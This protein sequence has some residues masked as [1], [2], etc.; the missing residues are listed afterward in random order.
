MSI[1]GSPHTHSSI[2]GDVSAP[3]GFLSLLKGQ[4]DLLLAGFLIAVV[5][6]FTLPLP[7]A[8][9]DFLIASNLCVS[10]VLLM[11]AMYV[12]SALSLSTFP[13]LLLFTT[14]FRLSLNIASAKLI[15]LHA[16]A[17]HIV[18]TFGKLIV[19]N[20]LVVG[21]V[22][23][24]II[25]IVQFIVIAKG[26]ERV[27]E[28]AARFALDAMPG[29]QMS[30]D[31][32]VRAG[33]M[34]SVQAQ[35]LRRE[36][37]QE[38][39]LQ[40]AMDGAMKFVKGDAIA[41]MVIALVNILA[42][43]AIGTLMKD[44]SIGAALQRYAILTIG[45]GMVSQIPSLLVSVAAGVVITRVASVNS[46]SSQL[47]GQI[48][49]QL[50]KHP[51]ALMV[52]ALPIGGFLLVPGFPV[53]AFGFWTLLV[54]GCGVVI[55]KQHQQGQVPSWIS[56]AE[57]AQGVDESAED[58][59][60][61]PMALRLSNSL[62]GHIDMAL[63]DRAMVAARKT[64]ERE[65]G[66]VFPHLQVAFSLAGA[67][68]HSYQVLV[69]DAVV[70]SGVLQQGRYLW[71]NHS[72]ET[73]ATA[74]PQPGGD[75]VQPFGPFAKPSWL[76]APPTDHPV[77]CCEEVL[78]AHVDHIAR[79]HLP[80]LIG[81]QE[82]Q[83]LLH[84]MQ[85]QAPELAAEVGRVVPPQRL[86]ETLKRL[87]QE[88]VP[89]RN[90]KLIFESLVLWV[91]QEPDAITLTERVRVDL[92]RYLTSRFVG[93]DRRLNAVMFDHALVDVMHNSIE[94][95]ARGN[96]L[97]LNPAIKESVLQQLGPLLYAAPPNTVLVV[98]TDIRRYVKT[99]IEATAPE[100]PVLSHQEIDP[101][102]ALHPV[103]WITHPSKTAN[104]T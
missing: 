39:Q 88:G 27:A 33:T 73:A 74:A 37:E 2:H 1:T 96:L 28:V 21:C 95:T 22:V 48:L 60:A 30:I 72:S 23:F 90:L 13:S 51:R 12:P 11:V 20:N 101:D 35:K 42:G 49:G 40:G 100:L 92:G 83:R 15:L 64:V 25:A 41:S 45:E 63:F 8:V 6:L 38:C 56:R 77:L 66:P 9:I 65:L 53:W 18:D 26:S 78:A 17:G 16:H 91:P 103:G 67:E 97:L 94:R 3:K 70:S 99:L 61:Y 68:P 87:L 19:G 76:D 46:E 81:L 4:N 75:P 5:T 44:M 79:R 24:L 34:T 36:L 43:V 82:V 93:P 52:A 7:A 31:A 55:W 50:A 14:L 62:R 104:P 69:Q 80:E 54:G 32:E 57:P 58:A 59:L 102:V 47:A 98:G 10:L 84:W 85:S 29:K 86:A 71:P 89:V